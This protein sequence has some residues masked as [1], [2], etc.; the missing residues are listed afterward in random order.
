VVWSEDGDHSLKPRVR[1]GRTE[2]QNLA[3]AVR[4]VAAFVNE[5]GR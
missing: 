4:V 1:S 2:A 3:E 5:L